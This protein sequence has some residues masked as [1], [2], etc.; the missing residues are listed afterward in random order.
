MHIV[1]GCWFGWSG[2]RYLG[3]RLNPVLSFMVA[4]GPQG[5]LEEADE[6]F[7][8]AIGIQEKALGPDH[9]GLAF[10]LS[11]RAN[12]LGEQVNDFSFLA[13]SLR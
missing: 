5:R 8:R 7:L 3:E 4:L 9:P 2:E 11:S 6:L 13:T 10:S 12:V 1:E